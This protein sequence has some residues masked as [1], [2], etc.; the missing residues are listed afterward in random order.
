MRKTISLTF[1]QAFDV[2]LAIGMHITALSELLESARERKEEK[3]ISQFEKD[4]ASLEQ[5][6][7]AIK[8][9]KW[10]V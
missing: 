10:I 9:A 3:L 8:E 1:D 2:C 6:K 4:I 7:A 5:A